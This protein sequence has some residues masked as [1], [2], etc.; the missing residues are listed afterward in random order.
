MEKQKPG[1]WVIQQEKGLP[2]AFGWKVQSLPRARDQ[3]KKAVK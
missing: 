1:F 2:I 3:N